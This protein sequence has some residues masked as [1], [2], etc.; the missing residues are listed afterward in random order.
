VFEISV[1]SELKT[2]LPK[3][4]FLGN[5]DLGVRKRGSLSWT[6]PKST[7]KRTFYS[8]SRFHHELC[9]Q[10]AERYKLHIGCLLWL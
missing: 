4:F 9:A 1:L 7:R 5:P 2:K 6:P 10:N 3:K 8:P